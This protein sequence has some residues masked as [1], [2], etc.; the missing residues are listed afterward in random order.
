MAVK[1]IIKAPD[2]LL[3][4]IS[5]PIEEFGFD[6][7]GLCHD[8]LDTMLANNGIGLAAIQIG[9]PKRVILAHLSN[10]SP[11]FFINP[12]YSVVGENTQTT[13]ETCL[14]VPCVSNDVERPEKI[15]LSYQDINGDKIQ[16]EYQEM[17][18]TIICHELEHLD[19]ILYIDH[20]SKLKRRMLLDKS[21]RKR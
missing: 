15:L 12:E 6:T 14:S 7:V 16:E 3:K 5:S 13:K 20:A 10:Q 9:V 4:T 11:K 17:D 2:P 21:I 1:R 18:A 8:M 19:G